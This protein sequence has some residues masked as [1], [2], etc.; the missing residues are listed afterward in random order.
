MSTAYYAVKPLLPRPLQIA[1]R[2]LWVKRQIARTRH[3]WPIWEDAAAPPPAWPGW[4]DGKR[5]ALVL[6]HDVESLFGV[7][8]CEQLARIEEERGFRST[9]GFVPLRYQTPSELRQAL[10]DRG[11]EVNVQGLYHDGKDF[12]NWHLFEKRRGAMNDFLRAWQ[13]RGFS[14]PSSLHNLA[15]L[16]ELDIDFDLSVFDVDPF[17]PQPCHFGRIFPFWVEASSGKGFVEIPNTLV[18]DFTLFILMRERSSAVWAKK[19]DWLAEKGGLALLKTH[20]D[21]MAFTDEDARMD[22]YPVRLYTE[23]LD[24]V[25]DRYSNQFW[26]AKPS[27]V[28]HY[29]RTLGSSPASNLLDFRNTYC[30]VCREAHRQDALRQY[31]VR[32]ASSAAYWAADPHAVP[33]NSIPSLQTINPAS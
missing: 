31:P 11:F 33:L 26:H 14:C 12:R 1:L 21:Y 17:E 6:A 32:V 28:A 9:F 2:R 23:F 22:R 30:E 4:P 13:S 7:G 5:F 10:V 3:C 15:W 18:Q 19:L 25:R 24:Y 27:E 29:W 8:H 16:S 20:P